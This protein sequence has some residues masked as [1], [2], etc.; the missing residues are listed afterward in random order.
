MNR[1][2]ITLTLQDI[3]RD[4]LDND[5]IAVFNDMRA[6]DVDN[7]D[8]LSHISIIASIEKTFSIRFSISEIDSITN[9]G[10]II[11]IIESA[12]LKK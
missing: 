9:V 1:E 7:W 2:Q 3:L 6:D 5:S 8:S 11:E 10:D 4:V 12:L